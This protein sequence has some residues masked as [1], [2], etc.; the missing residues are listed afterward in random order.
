MSQGFT[1]VASIQVRIK[2][3]CLL[4]LPEMLTVAHLGRFRV[5]GAKV[6]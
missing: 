3:T 6:P 1:R 2:D 5:A 4:S